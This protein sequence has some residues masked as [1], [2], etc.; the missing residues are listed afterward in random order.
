MPLLIIVVEFMRVII[1]NESMKRG[2]IMPTARTYT[3]KEAA[4]YLTGM[5]GQNMIYNVVATGLY[6]YFQ[7]VICLD[8]VALGW[9]FT[10]ARVWDAVN[11]PI[12]GAIVDKT[13]TKWGKCK[14]YLMFVPALICLITCVTFLNGNYAAAK[15]VAEATGGEGAVSAKMV[16]IL[17]WAAVSYILWGMS[18]TIGDIPLW[19]IISRMSEVEEDRAKLISAARVVASVGAAAVVVSIVAVSQAA[20]EAFGESTNAQ[21][22]FIVVGIAM[23][24]VA[25]LLFEVAGIGVKERVPVSE[26]KK[27]MKESIAL[28]WKCVPFR[29]IIISG[30]LRSPLQ[31]MMIVILTLFTYYFCDGN[32]QKAF[33]DPK[34]LVILIILGGGYFVGQ[35][36]AM[37]LCPFAMRKI[38]VKTLYNLTAVSAVPTAAV[39]LTFLADPTG[40]HQMKWVI[41][42]GI[43]F[44]ISGMGFGVINVCQ[45]IMISDCI[46]YEE[47]HNG[48]RPD[49]IFFSGQ[50]FITKLSAGVATIISQYVFASV[51]YTDTNIDNM[52]KALENGAHFATD[53]QVYSKAMWFILTV[54]PAIG[55]ALAVIPTLRYEITP[56]D[57]EKMLAELVERHSGGNKKEPGD[58]NETEI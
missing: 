52:N 12:M 49:G 33:T 15:E 57:H 19:G 6:F 56:A 22:G 34:I 14:P 8:A 30:I 53:Y 18:Y 54:P 24:V 3:K 45:S 38:S 2:V 16:L 26:E 50:S 42:N 23:T 43:C 47:Y 32:L 13:N 20:N 58:N 9:I 28:M 29:R 35:F 21:K 31:L 46:D 1:Y 48:Y 55:I 27:T 4:M 7:N 11:D 51:G 5:F 39:F 37:I 41:I 40:L 25:S 36:A 10:V 44:L 17:T